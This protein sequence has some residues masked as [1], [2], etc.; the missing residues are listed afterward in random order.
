[1]LTS[2]RKNHTQ[3]DISGETFLRE[4]YYLHSGNLF[5]S[6]FNAR[7]S[8][9]AI[10]N[11]D[12]YQPSLGIFNRC[13]WINGRLNCASFISRQGESFGN[14]DHFPVAWQA[15]LVFFSVGLCFLVLTLLAS[16][17]GWCFRSIRRKS[18][19]SISGS[20]QALA[21]LV[22]LCQA[23]KQGSI[24]LFPSIYLQCYSSSWAL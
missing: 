16:I 8:L 18:I 9:I 1:M 14:S 6:S 10:S 20:V 21:G 23:K 2:S 5:Y 24:S 15:S 22:I 3:Q 13:T 19:F 11:A 17:L 7:S 4:H 12:F